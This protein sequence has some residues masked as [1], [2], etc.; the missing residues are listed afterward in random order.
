MEESSSDNTFGMALQLKDLLW[1]AES[2]DAEE[3]MQAALDKK[4]PK[5]ER[6][7]SHQ[8]ASLA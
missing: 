7:K 2:F 6:Q 4:S 5:P 3:A 1:S 8:L